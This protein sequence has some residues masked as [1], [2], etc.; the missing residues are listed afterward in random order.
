[1]A[2]SW[3]AE[4]PGRTG[5]GARP[6]APALRVAALVVGLVW[7]L[8]RLCPRGF[9]EPALLR[10]A[11]TLAD[12]PMRTAASCA[13]LAWAVTLERIAPQMPARGPATGDRARPGQADPGKIGPFDI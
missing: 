13:F 2:V 8:D 7:V 6:I 5:S 11:R 4:E 3:S 12:H 10:W 9:D 1:M